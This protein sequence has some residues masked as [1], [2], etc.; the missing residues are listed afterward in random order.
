MAGIVGVSNVMIIVVKERTREIGV[1]KALGAKPASIVGMIIQ[2][3]VFITT[4]A[5]YIGL[6]LGIVLLEGLNR[7][8]VAFG[9]ELEFFNQPEIDLR[10]ALAALLVLVLSGALAGLVPAMK[11][12]RVSPAEALRGK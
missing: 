9:A 4:I 6:F 11:A 8:L 3:S 2:E 10:V 1:R 5:G 7:A 12:A